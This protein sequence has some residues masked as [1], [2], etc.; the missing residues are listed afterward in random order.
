MLIF[1]SLITITLSQIFTRTDNY[2]YLN[3]TGT[4]IGFDAVQGTCTGNPTSCSYGRI[5]YCVN[6]PPALIP[7][8]YG[9][10]TYTTNDCSGVYNTLT[11]YKTNICIQN[12]PLNSIITSCF[13]TR[14]QV[15]TYNN[16][17]KCSVV[18]PVTTVNVIA[19][20]TPFGASQTGSNF[21][22]CGGSSLPITTTGSATT[23]AT[24]TSSPSGTVS[25]FHE[26]TSIKYNFNIY[27]LK[28][29]QSNKNKDCRIPHIVKTDGLAIQTSCGDEVLRLTND[30]LVY[31]KSNTATNT[32]FGTSPTRSIL[33]RADR[34]QIGS[35]LFTED[36]SC[37][38]TT[39]EK[40]YN[41]N[42]FGLNCIE[43]EVLANGYKTSTFGKYHHLPAFWMKY[44]SKILG[45]EDAS[46][47]GD[48]IAQFFN[49]IK[50]L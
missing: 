18:S 6:G 7:G 28:D 21:G 25:C 42:Y 44:G 49:N 2:Q 8:Y 4:V 39:I 35:I 32:L 5:S 33:V 30:H 29:F 34:L 38:V 36:K 47:L 20:C 11:N 17:V 1:L 24:T 46:S 12:G 16:N 10:A 31:T 22:L 27:T 15:Q 50:L 40:E 26:S 37:E 13:G 45:L 3:C 9:A 48:K 19:G 41:Q 43:S 23:T 14:Y